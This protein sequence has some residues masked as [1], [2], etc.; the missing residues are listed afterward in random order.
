[1]HVL[2]WVIDGLVAGW[3]TGK[4]LEGE[5]RDLVMDATMGVAGAIA[6]GFLF[7]ATHLLVRGVMIYTNLAA[8]LGAV[9][10]TVVSRYIGGRR[11]HSSTN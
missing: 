8:I 6:G 7:S 2:L 9:V 4:A 3:V 1:M 10:L 5:G 11:E